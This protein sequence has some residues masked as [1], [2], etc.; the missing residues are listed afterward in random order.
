MKSTLRICNLQPQRW[1][2]VNNSDSSCWATHIKAKPS[3]RASWQ[4]IMIVSRIWWWILNS[5]LVIIHLWIMEIEMKQ[6]ILGLV[7]MWGSLRVVD[8]VNIWHQYD[9]SWEI[10]TVWQLVLD[11]PL[12]NQITLI[13][14][15]QF[16]C[17]EMISEDWF[18]ICHF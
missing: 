9:K 17:K 6:Q 15:I 3:K 10:F 12:Y 16:K 14:W 18:W 4:L 13:G 8:C 11:S 7:V 1:G 2:L 5:A